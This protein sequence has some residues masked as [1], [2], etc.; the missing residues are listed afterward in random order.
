MLGLIHPPSYPFSC[1]SALFP[2]CECSCLCGHWSSS[3]DSF[4]HFAKERPSIDFIWLPELAGISVSIPF[5]STSSF[6]ISTAPLPFKLEEP[7][8]QEFSRSLRGKQTMLCFLVQRNHQE[9][10]DVAQSFC[11]G[12]LYN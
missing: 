2:C 4:I 5:S 6:M 11:N 1:F 7:S 8:R 10:F 3:L 9:E 12:G